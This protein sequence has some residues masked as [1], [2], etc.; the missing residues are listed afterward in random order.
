MVKLANTQLSK[1]CDCKSFAGS[2]P[3]PGTNM[4]RKPKYEVP[5]WNRRLAYAVGLVTTDGSLSKDKRHVIFTS[6]DYQLIKIFLEC[7]GKSNSIG[8]YKPRLKRKT[9]YH[10]QISDVTLYR[11]LLALGLTPNKSLTLASLKIPN[12]Y[13]VDFLRGHLDGD[14][15]IITYIDRYNTKINSKYVYTRLFVYLISA[16]KQHVIWL[17][18]KITKLVHIKGSINYHASTWVLKFSTKEAKILLN[19]IYY[20]DDLPKLERKWLIAKPFLAKLK[21]L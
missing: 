10:T 19:W 11:W 5:V 13:F 2:S 21:E 8:K 12:K 4:P 14:G 16:S 1:S 17:Q 20:K 6:T 9:A 7:I 15:S 3:A 18:D